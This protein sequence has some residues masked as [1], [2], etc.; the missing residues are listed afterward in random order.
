MKMTER[1][2]FSLLLI[3]VM[4]FFVI[5]AFNYN[6]QARL[7]P[8]VVGSM[9]LIMLIIQFLGETV[10]TFGKRFPFLS[11]QGMFSTPPN[12]EDKQGERG[13]TL[14]E[15]APWTSVLVII[16]SIIGFII[17]LYYTNY[18]VAV[19]VFLFTVL[20]LIGKEKPLKGLGIAIIMTLF[21]Y[22]LF[23]LVLN[24]RF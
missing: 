15:S 1:S 20:C 6:P 18:L 23:D 17:V 2:I 11:Q 9:T 21:M 4:T 14:D 7:F 24:T 10:R 13:Q 5:I 8:L 22:I 3:L 16:M 12:K 19:F